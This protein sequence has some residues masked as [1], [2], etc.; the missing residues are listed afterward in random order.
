M[1][2]LRTRLFSCSSWLLPLLTAA[3][4]AACGGGGGGSANPLPNGNALSV[5]VSGNGR[6]V[7]APAG[8]D[9]GA[10]CSTHFDPA[11]S[12]TLSATPATGQVFG[13]WGG[14]CA[15]TAA[16]CTLTMEAARTVTASF[17]APPPSSFTLGV[18]VSGNGT[19]RSQPA[20]ID[21]GSTCNAPFAANTSVVLSATPTAGS[22]FAG[23]SGACSNASGTCTVTMDAA[24]T[25]TANF[26]VAVLPLSVS[27]SFSP[28]TVP[29]GGSAQ[30]IVT[31]VNPNSTNTG[32]QF[33][34]NLPDRKSVV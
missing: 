17:N 22:T 9:C 12:V 32:S 3:C 11:T 14:D 5:S 15:G 33:T 4:L 34:L 10:T 25:V 7:S 20:G 24:K 27:I 1:P 31:V 23:W 8:I 29:A 19:L 2:L 21:C 26:A 28:A 6:V 30:M 13:G 18:N 16:S